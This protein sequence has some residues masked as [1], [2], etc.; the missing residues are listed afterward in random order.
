MDGHRYLVWIGVSTVGGV[1]D[2]EVN[3]TPVSQPAAAFTDDLG[4]DRFARTVQKQAE[5]LAKE[6]G[7]EYE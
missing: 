3:Y 2:Q 7:V 6:Y 5:A 1:Y 4:A